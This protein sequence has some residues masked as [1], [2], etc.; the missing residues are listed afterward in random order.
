M[1]TA[2]TCIHLFL[3]RNHHITTLVKSDGHMPFTYISLHSSTNSFVPFAL[4]TIQ[5]SAGIPTGP[6]ALPTFSASQGLQNS[7][8]CLFF[9]R[10]FLR[11]YLFLNLSIFR[12][13]ILVMLLISS[14]HVVYLHRCLMSILASI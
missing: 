4:S 10:G 1:I 11:A 9:F 12:L 2:L 7:H 6:I 5:N 3:Q 14:S 8:S 13:I